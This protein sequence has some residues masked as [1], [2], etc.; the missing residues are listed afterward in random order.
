[1]DCGGQCW[2]GGGIERSGVLQVELHHKI[3]TPTRQGQPQ[4]LSSGQ[5]QAIFSVIGGCFEQS[6]GTKG[7]AIRGVSE[8]SHVFELLGSQLIQILTCKGIILVDSN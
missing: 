5:Q 7:Q 1:M 6:K 8:E 3:D 4:V 2:T